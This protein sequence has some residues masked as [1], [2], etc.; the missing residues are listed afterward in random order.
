MDK[1]D[2]KSA[3]GA[4]PRSTPDRP[5]E[6]VLRAPLPTFTLSLFA[7]VIALCLVVGST[8]LAHAENII[9]VGVVGGERS[10]HA[11]T[12]TFETSLA[13]DGRYIQIG[14]ATLIVDD[15]S[16]TNAGWQVTIS[17]LAPSAPDSSD[18]NHASPEIAMLAGLS[19]PQLLA[20]QRIDGHGGPFLPGVNAAGD[21]RSPRTVLVSEP[22]F[23]KG[24]YRQEITI[25]RT[26][27]SDPA[28]RD[29]TMTLSVTIA[30]RS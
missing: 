9:S 4:C 3:N 29:A 17:A 14:T 26:L 11:S 27:P 24:S 18:G 1:I 16:G 7:A 20:G 25:V 6:S 21:L 8:S 12:V 10:A 13:A 23:G 5:D 19:A 30:P 22:G 15:A 2:V 28:A